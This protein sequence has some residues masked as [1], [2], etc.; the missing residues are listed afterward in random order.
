ML[1]EQRD[2]QIYKLVCLAFQTLLF[3]TRLKIPY[4]YTT[5]N[6]DYVFGSGFCLDSLVLSIS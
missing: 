2:Y 4:R 6:N 5:T 1:I 3:L